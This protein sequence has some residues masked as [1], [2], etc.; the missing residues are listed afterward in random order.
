MVAG[1]TSE[2]RTASPF[3]THEFAPGFCVPRVA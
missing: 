1:A 2:A 3:G